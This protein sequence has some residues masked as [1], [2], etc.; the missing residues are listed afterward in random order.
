MQAV[1][2]AIFEEPVTGTDLATQYTYDVVSDSEVTTLA[3]AM[4]PDLVD[5]SLCSTTGCG[6][7]PPADELLVY[8][9]GNPVV[10]SVTPSSG[11][12]SGGTAVVIGGQNLGCAISVSFGS[13]VAENF[14]NEPALLDC[15]TTGLVDATSPSGTPATRVAVTVQTS[16]ELLHRD[17][18]DQLGAV[19]L[20]RGAGVTSHNQ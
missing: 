11:P 8:P 19:P 1:G 17:G 7:N 20:H 3:P 14:A 18:G 10:T 6:I 15:G 4:N 13:V 2:P 12:A 9:P 5:V 16:R